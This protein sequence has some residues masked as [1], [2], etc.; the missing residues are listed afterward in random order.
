MAILEKEVEISLHG[1]N[2]KYFEKLGY[3]IPRRKD[4]Q[5]RNR[6]E[7]GAKITVKVE[8]LAK[9]SSALVTKICDDCG[10]IVE[11]I[12]YSSIA[13][14]RGCRDG[15]DRCMNCAWK[16]GASINRSR[17]LEKGNSIADTDPNLASLFYY[18]EDAHKHSA[19]S[20][21]RAY[22]RCPSCDSKLLKTVS[23]V[24]HK[25][26]Y[27]EF[28]D[29]SLPLPEKFTVALLKQLGINF[30]WEKF[31]EWSDKKIYD[32]YIEDK[33]MI[34]ETHGEQHYGL[35]FE[36]RGGRSL[37]EEQENDKL[38]YENAMKNGI[39]NYF[40][41]DCRK[42]ELDYLKNSFLN[43]ELINFYDL[44]YVDWEECYKSACSQLTHEAWRLW[45]DGIKQLSEIAK[46]IN[47][48][49]ETV[50]RFLKQGVSLGKCD[51]DAEGERSISP[52]VQLSL[53][54]GE[55]I[56][57]HE[58]IVK[59]IED[60]GVFRKTN[61]GQNISS[62]CQGKQQSAFGYR[63]MYK[64]DYDKY[65]NGEIDLPPMLD[66]RFN[67]IVQLTKEGEFIAE[68]EGILEASQS[69]GLHS[70]NSHLIACCK[71]RKKSAFGFIWMYK[72]DYIKYLNGEIELS[73]LSVPRRSIAVVQLDMNN[74][75]FISEYPAVTDGANAIGVGKGRG[76]IT[77]C[78]KGE[79]EFA[80]GFKWM[81]KE[82]YIKY[83]N[84]EIELSSLFVSRKPT[85][86][87]NKGKRTSGENPRARA[88]VQL[89]M[90]TL[91]FISEYPTAT[92]GANAIGGGKGRPNITNCCKGERKS[93][94]G[95]KWMYKDDYEEKFGKY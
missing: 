77:K 2:V 9:T 5:G 44:T 91:N 78:C 92:D 23:I 66:N 28:C 25:G 24:R 3:E 73:P 64:E 51:Y 15:K 40:I 50:R 31:F 88:V 82:D 38:K 34:I 93:A 53:A 65:L 84:G 36:Y 80:Y 57:E 83:L 7:F 87:P 67:I 42:S 46:I 49:P 58:S 54:T 95:F 35:G 81:Y 69:I 59:A 90:N 79:R 12:P 14:S 85:P 60:L 26:L 76:N 89:D 30:E 63:W 1:R 20:K 70:S 22:F 6:I 86:S 18:E 11:N 56:K 33:N 29:D 43:S 19:H 72:E 16:Y 48:S 61:S 74:L 4:K 10:C 13:L 47:V 71:G 37:E 27:C 52:V 55:F 75:S 41:I 17:Y 94:L 8:H 45:N 62:T 21:K 39:E 32:F 68:H